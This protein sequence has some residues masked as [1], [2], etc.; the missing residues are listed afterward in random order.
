MSDEYGPYIYR[1]DAQGGLL[2]TIQ[3][4]DAI[5]PLVDGELNFTSVDDPDT[6]R[7]GNQGERDLLISFCQ[8]SPES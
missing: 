7:A 5:V 8:S 1:F 4:P 6:G 3:P 2:Q